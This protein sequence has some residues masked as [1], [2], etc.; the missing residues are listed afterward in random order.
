MKR[1]EDYDGHFWKTRRFLCKKDGSGQQKIRPPKKS[2]LS[3]KQGK[4]KNQHVALQERKVVVSF[5][6]LNKQGEF[7]RVT[8]SF[9]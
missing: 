5:H 4:K 7:S 8:P 6:L 3:S 1:K 2:T 9:R